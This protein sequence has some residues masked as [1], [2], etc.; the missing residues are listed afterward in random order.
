MPADNVPERQ[1]LSTAI[2]NEN[3]LTAAFVLATVFPYIAAIVTAWAPGSQPDRKLAFVLASVVIAAGLVEVFG[4]A[5]M[6]ITVIVSYF[7]PGWAS[8]NHVLPLIFEMADDYAFF[9]GWP[10]E[11]ILSVLVPVYLRR[12]YWQG[13][14]ETLFTSTTRRI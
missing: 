4:L 1:K 6:I 2:V 8:A 10:A 3:L 5:I 7:N 14:S 12:R 9:L 11:F 13:L